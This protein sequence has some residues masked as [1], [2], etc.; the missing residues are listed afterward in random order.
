[1][2]TNSQWIICKKFG[3]VKNEVCFKCPSAQR[4]GGR[5]KNY[6]ILASTAKTRGFAKRGDTRDA[7]GEVEHDNSFLDEKTQ[8]AVDKKQSADVRRRAISRVYARKVG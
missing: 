6:V 2:T 1:M 5:C 7:L 8:E 3:K 4:Q